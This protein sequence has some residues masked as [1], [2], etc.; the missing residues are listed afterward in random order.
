MKVE[1]Y[2][3][4]EMVKLLKE[5]EVEVRKLEE[6]KDEVN[7]LWLKFGKEVS[8]TRRLKRKT[9][10]EVAK[11]IGISKSAMSYL[12]LGQRTW[13]LDMAIKTVQALRD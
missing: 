13:N 10:D 12:E 6:Q 9:L 8:D 2:L 4:E 7:K 3:L 1:I 5:I 11:K